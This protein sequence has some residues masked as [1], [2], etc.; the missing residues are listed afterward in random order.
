M[1]IMCFASFPLSTHAALK[2]TIRLN[3]TGPDVVFLQRFL[4]DE[5]YLN[6]QPAILGVFG[7]RATRALKE[8]QRLNG[9]EPT[10]IAGPIT[11]SYINNFSGSNATTSTQNISNEKLTNAIEH[12][13]SLATL[14]VLVEFYTQPGDSEIAQV[15]S[16]GGIIKRTYHFVPVIAANIPTEKILALSKEQNVKIIELDQNAFKR[17][18]AATSSLPI[19]NTTSTST[20]VVPQIIATSTSIS[21]AVIDSGIDY[22]HPDLAPYYAGGYN[23]IN[24]T[25]DAMD[26]NNHGTHVAGIILT[27]FKQ[28]IGNQAGVP[29]IKL[30][31]LK[32]LDDKGS[33]YFSDIIAALE[34]AVDHHM[35]ITNNSY[36]SNTDPG[37][38]VLEA[39]NKADH[40]GVLSVAAAGNSGSC[41]SDTDTVEFPARYPSVVAVAAFDTINKSRPCFSSTGEDVEIAAPGVSILSTKRGG[42]YIQYSGTSMASPYVSGGAAVIFA[43]NSNKYKRINDAVRNILEQNSDDIGTPGRDLN[44]G[45]GI[46]NI[47]RA[48]SFVKTAAATPKMLNP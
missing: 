3:S 42:G 35:T 2:K 12:A 38:I 25:N 39:F 32:V 48:L 4:I 45:F 44:F 29:N 27:I 41:N 34:W 31:S 24:N 23:F 15:Q 46:I 19:I 7:P 1:C 28:Y 14:P 18:D 16:Y 6:Y 11:R 17:L 20:I 47:D 37:R 36:G 40:A 43:K 9:I 8:F 26:D 30:F 5:T 13:A 22:T 21:V 10:G 33:G